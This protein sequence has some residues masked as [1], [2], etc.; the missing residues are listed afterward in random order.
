MN[1]PPHRMEIYTKPDHLLRQH[2]AIFWY[3]DYPSSSGYGDD[4][5]RHERGQHFLCELR[6]EWDNL[7]VKD[8]SS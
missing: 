2:V 5:I 3:A 7:K 8:L 1:E 6:P 4:K